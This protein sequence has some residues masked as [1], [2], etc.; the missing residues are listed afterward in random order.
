MALVVI[1][2]VIGKY[3]GFDLE[4]TMND[5]VTIVGTIGVIYFRITAKKALKLK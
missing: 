3:I 2:P 1:A 4:A 5:I